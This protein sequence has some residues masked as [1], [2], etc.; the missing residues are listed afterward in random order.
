MEMARVERMNDLVV[1]RKRI[2]GTARSLA[3]CQELRLATMSESL[4]VL[5]AS[6]VVGNRDQAS[7]LIE[8]ETLRLLQPIDEELRTLGVD[9]A[10]FN[11]H[12]ESE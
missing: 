6:L 3:E 2:V 8:K 12:Q 5:S 10:P 9:V 7:D 4:P 1:E 11:L